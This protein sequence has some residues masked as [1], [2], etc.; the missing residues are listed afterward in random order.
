[1]GRRTAILFLLV[2]A[3]ALLP[4]SGVARA[5]HTTGGADVSVHGAIEELDVARRLVDESIQ[6]YQDGRTEAAYS[7]ARNSYLD[8]FEYVEIPLRVRDEGL[9]L[10]VEEDYAALR[11]LIEAGAPLNDVE[12]VS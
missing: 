1:M 3:F 2:G 5:E 12:A 11:N 9:T 8:H 4:L 10:A 6:L 7:A